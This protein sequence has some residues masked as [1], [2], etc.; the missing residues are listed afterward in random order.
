MNQNVPYIC[1]T[2]TLSAAAGGIAAAMFSQI[3]AGKP[4]LSMII[5]GILAG[6][7]SITAGCNVIPLGASWIVGFIGG[8]LVVFSVG[9]IDK[10]RIDD[11]VGAWSV[12]GTNGIWGTL[13]VG[14]FAKNQGLFYGHGLQQ[15][16]IQLVGVLA[17]AVEAI[18]TGIILWNILAVI[19]DGI[20]VTDSEEIEGL[21]IG[22]HGMEAYPDFA[23]TAR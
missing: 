12:H 16:G 7:V 5:N 10:L 6:L 1:V 11:P 4:D 2:T 21:D 20:R 23:P 18:L 8:T 19:F 9:W 3:T 13:A 17:I 22:E 14:L 15:L